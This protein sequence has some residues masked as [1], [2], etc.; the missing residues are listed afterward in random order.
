MDERVLRAL[1][2]RACQLK[3]EDLERLL[4]G[5]PAPVRRLVEEHWC[6]RALRGQ[7]EPE[8]DWRV[9][10]MMAGRGFGKTRTGAEWLWSR[11]R[12]R[13]GAGAGCFGSRWWGRTWT[14]SRR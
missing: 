6:L 1:V 13:G 2:H 8:G 5:L 7:F 3:E 10:L 11:V 4:K 9:W 12:A 14:M